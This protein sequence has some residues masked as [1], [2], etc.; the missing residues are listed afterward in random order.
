MER[1]N[2]GN[3]EFIRDLG[4]KLRLMREFLRFN[5]A[6]AATKFDFASVQITRYESGRETQN[7]LYV[8]RITTECGLKIEDLML[9]RND[10]IQKLYF[11]R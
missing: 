6:E 9:E 8:Y 3:R 11:G 7:L 5:V 10:F 1:I 2:D 4:F